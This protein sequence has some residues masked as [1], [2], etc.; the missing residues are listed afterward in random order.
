MFAFLQV[1]V[2]YTFCIR[3]IS[4]L[5][6]FRSCSHIRS[7]SV[8]FSFAFPVRFL[9]IG[10]VRQDSI[11]KYKDTDVHLSLYRPSY[12]SVYTIIPLCTHYVYGSIIPPYTCTWHFMQW[13]GVLFLLFMDNTSCHLFTLSRQFSNIIK[14]LPKDI[15]FKLWQLDAS[16]IVNWKVLYTN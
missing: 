2:L 1:P 14:F 10:T 12:T 16:I 8:P 5:Y 9:L 11:Q 4:V 13:E 15:K 6:L 3:S 7:V